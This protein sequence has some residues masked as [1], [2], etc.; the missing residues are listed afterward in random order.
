MPFVN[1]NGQEALALS[2]INSGIH[3]LAALL[4]KKIMGNKILTQ[5]LQ[6]FMKL[7]CGG[8]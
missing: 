8:G 2:E 6:M 1:R 4:F 7:Q 5:R 3:N